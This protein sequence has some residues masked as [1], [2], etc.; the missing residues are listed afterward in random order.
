MSKLRA[1]EAA[2]LS[3]PGPEMHAWLH[4][5][6]EKG[7]VVEV[8]FAGETAWLILSQTALA[9]AFKD[10]RMFPAGEHYKRVLEPSQGPT[11]QGREGREHHLLRS[12]ATPAFRPRALRSWQ[13]ELSPLAHEMVDRF[14][15]EG[16]VD[17]VERFT[18]IYPFLVISRMLGIPPEQEDQFHGWA[19]AMLRF[20][21]EANREFS[22]YMLPVMAERRRQPGD[23]V[24]SGLL[25]AEV[26]GRRFS[27]EEVLAHVRLLFSAGATTTFDALGTLLFALLTHPD[28][29]ERVHSEEDALEKAVEELFRWETPVANLPRRTLGGGELAGVEIPPRSMLLFSITGANHDPEFFTEPE[30][31]DIDRDTRAKLTFGLGSHSC[32]GFHLAR[33]ELVE[34]TRVLL[35]RLPELQLEDEEVAQPRGFA[36]RGSQSLPVSFRPG[37]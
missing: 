21:P 32:P 20:D 8:P 19:T 13:D 18:K 15:G 11:F 2:E 24:M 30:V 12:L 37:S 36:L 1:D 28:V 6:R 35:E 10:E 27:D 14:V 33:N 16:R 22:E 9:T 7:P 31:F 34:A 3:F 26:D 17:L 29:L 23:D 4:G 5:L 25:H